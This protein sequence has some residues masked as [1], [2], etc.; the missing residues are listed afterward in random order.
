MY[1]HTAAS[2]SEPQFL[3]EFETVAAFMRI[4]IPVRRS[5]ILALYI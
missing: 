5:S 2:I 1:L 3:Y 4:P